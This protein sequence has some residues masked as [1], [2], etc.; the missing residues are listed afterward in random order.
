MKK[1]LILILAF[2][3]AG[4]FAEMT[5]T[6]WK[7][8]LFADAQDSKARC[9]LDVAEGILKEDLIKKHGFSQEEVVALAKEYSMLPKNTNHLNLLDFELRNV[10]NAGLNY[11]IGYAP[12]EVKVPDASSGFSMPWWG[13][14]LVVLGGGGL[15][16]AFSRKRS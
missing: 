11:F 7:A 4:G 9:S 14:A 6:Q 8:K 5:K 10:A 1:I 12:V 15:L 2:T 13:W 16:Y 3:A